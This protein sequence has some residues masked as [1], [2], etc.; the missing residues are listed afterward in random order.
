MGWV[1]ARAWVRPWTILG[2]CLSAGCNNFS[3]NYLR[4]GHGIAIADSETGRL[5]GSPTVM[6]AGA[7][8]ISQGF[9]PAPALRYKRD[10][11]AIHN[12]IDIVA[13]RGTPVY[14]V[15]TGTV[16]VSLFE[17]LYGHRVEVDHP[18]DADG[19]RYRTRYFH[20]RK[21]LVA[22]GT[23]VTTDRPIGELGSSGLMAAFPHLH[24]EV[25]VLPNG[26]QRRAGGS[27]VC[28][29]EV[30]HPHSRRERSGSAPPRD[31]LG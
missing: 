7:P 1:R 3:G 8:S 24:L 22:A 6:P 2:I 19:N 21:R 26:R 18:A 17:P 20:L 14:A 9:M 29:E 15:A 23:A 4:P 5:P 16:R 28:P 13:R 11:L 30:G 31:R 27:P 25:S 12:G 10:S